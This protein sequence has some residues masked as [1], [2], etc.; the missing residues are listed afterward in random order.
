MSV[1]NIKAKV[2]KLRARVRPLIP[3]RALIIKPLP[4]ETDE[5]ATARTLATYPD[6]TAAPR[7]ILKLN[8]EPVNL[9]QQE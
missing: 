5:Q 3:N 7:M 8:T 9:P 2:K 4:C 1:K 6:M